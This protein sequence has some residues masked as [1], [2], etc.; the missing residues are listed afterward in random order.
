MILLQCHLLVGRNGGLMTEFQVKYEFST[1]FNTIAEYEYIIS[2]IIIL[3]L[4][5]FGDIN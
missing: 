3:T 1:S 5:R 2:V 4:L